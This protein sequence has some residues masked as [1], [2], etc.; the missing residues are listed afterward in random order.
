MS[1]APIVK[2]VIVKPPPARAFDLFAAQMGRWWPSARTPGKTPA[3]DVVVEPRA[4]GRWFERDAD[5][6]ETLWGEVLAY[7]PPERLLLGWKLDANFTYDPKLLMEVEITFSL[8]SG[9]GTAVRLEH[10]QL[11][12]LGAD[13]ERFAARINQGWPERLAEYKTY[14]ETA[15]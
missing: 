14:A 12:R 1:I 13:A 11:E 10:R 2:S 15:R 7:E 8:A 9:G 6:V 5:G 4:G 3:V